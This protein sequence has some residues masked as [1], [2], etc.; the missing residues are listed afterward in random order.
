MK[1]YFAAA[2]AA[3]IVAAPAHAASFNGGFVGT[4]IF[5][6]GYEVK[7]DDT[8]IYEDEDGNSATISADGISANG[9]G[10][11]VY[12]G[13]DAAIG[14]GFFAGIEANANISGAS[15]SVSASETYEG[16]TT[17]VGGKVKAQAGYGVSARLGAEVIDGTGVYARSGGRTPGSSCR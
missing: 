4:Q 14:S 2:A 12:A 13:Y 16:E 10:V 6:D 7:A 1:T 9:F 3:L 17:T 5:H 8:V 11:G 15:A